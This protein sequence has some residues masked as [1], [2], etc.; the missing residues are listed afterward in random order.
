MESKKKGKKERERKKE[1]VEEGNLRKY[2]EYV[3]INRA[4]LAYCH[5]LVSLLPLAMDTEGARAEI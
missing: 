5:C 2:V 3:E 1:T 4:R